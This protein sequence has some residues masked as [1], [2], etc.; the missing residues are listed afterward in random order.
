MSRSWPKF[1]Q[2]T[3]KI[4]KVI[5]LAC[6]KRQQST[7]FVKVPLEKEIAFLNGIDKRILMFDNIYI[8]FGNDIFHSPF[9]ICKW[10]VK[11][12]YFTCKRIFQIARFI[13]FS[14]LIYIFHD[15]NYN[16]YSSKHLRHS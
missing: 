15:K 2:A 1:F 7:N 5:V 8:L 13:S 11:C 9:P 4:I 14:F 12:N 16:Y 10:N 3:T 6:C